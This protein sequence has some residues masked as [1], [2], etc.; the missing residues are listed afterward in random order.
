MPLSPLPESNTKRYFLQ[1]VVDTE[2]HN[3]QFRCADSIGDSTA[4]SNIA[5]LVTAIAPTAGTNTTY[6]GVFVALNG[7]NVRNPVPG[8]TPVTGAGGLVSGATLQNAWC[9]SGR[10]PSG[11][12]VKIFLF[13]LFIALPADYKQDPL[14]DAGLQGFQ[15]LLNSQSD[16]SLA[17]DGT[18]PTWYFRA[19]AKANDHWVDQVR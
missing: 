16:F 15:G 2:I 18:K 17:I 14:T 10:A 7:S 4:L 13:G 19:T 11:R 8:F 12:K 9:I 1:Y 5:D 3:M 6:D